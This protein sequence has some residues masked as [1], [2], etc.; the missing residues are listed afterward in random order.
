[1]PILNSNSHNIEQTKYNK[2]YV[3]P[4]ISGYADVNTD[5]F[6]IF[7]FS[8]NGGII[9]F[10]ETTVTVL[11]SSN[12]MIRFQIDEKNY[13]LILPSVPNVSQIYYIR[14]VN[15]NNPIFMKIILSK[16]NTAFNCGVNTNSANHY[17]TEIDLTKD[18]ATYTLTQLKDNILIPTDSFPFIEYEH[19]INVLVKMEKESGASPFAYR[20]N[21]CHI[22]YN[23]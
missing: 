23:D 8:S 16:S 21:G 14:I 20:V 9:N 11:T 6:N 7:S 18:N 4:S 17:F 2:Y 22:L 12:A 19:S 13:D 3:A 10:I 15:M 1:M 5:W